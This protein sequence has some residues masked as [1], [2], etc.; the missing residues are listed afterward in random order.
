MASVSGAGCCR[1][2]ISA[3]KPGCR[4]VRHAALTSAGLQIGGCLMGPT[5]IQCMASASWAGY[6]RRVVSAF[7]PGCR[8]VRHAALSPRDSESGASHGPYVHLRHGL[9][10]QG[11]LP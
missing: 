5:S 6:R 9:C 1:R 8:R 3:S 11:R 10:L 2:A 7:E 4:R